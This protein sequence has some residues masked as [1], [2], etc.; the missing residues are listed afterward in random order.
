MTQFHSIY[1][2]FQCQLKPFHFD[3]FL[4]DIGE[5]LLF[6]ILSCMVRLVFTERESERNRIAE[7]NSQ[8]YEQ[9]PQRVEP[10][11]ILRHLHIAITCGTSASDCAACCRL[12]EGRRRS[13]Q[14]ILRLFTLMRRVAA[15]NVRVRKQRKRQTGG[16]TGMG[17]WGRGKATHTARTCQKTFWKPS[18][19]RNNNDR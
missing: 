11:I 13:S 4:L 15:D 16:S 14:D 2:Y 12:E 1:A 10:Q 6:S 18:I 3:V 5:L 8:N 17:Q 7:N 9:M 19:G